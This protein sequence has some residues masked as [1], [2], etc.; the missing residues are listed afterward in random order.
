MLGKVPR[1]TQLARKGSHQSRPSSTSWHRMLV[2]APLSGRSITELISNQGQ[3]SISLHRKTYFYPSRLDRASSSWE[4]PC[5]LV[6]VQQQNLD[7]SSHPFQTN[8]Q[9]F[10]IFPLFLFWVFFSFLFH[11]Q[12]GRKR[13][14]RT[15]GWEEIKI[16]CDGVAWNG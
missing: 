3:R 16:L 7:F 8:A 4:D 9:T 11:V 14:G 2:Q 13:G 6:V 5:I 15:M 10:R 1:L 12:K